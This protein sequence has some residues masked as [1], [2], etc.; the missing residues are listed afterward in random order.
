MEAGPGEKSEKVTLKQENEA[1]EQPER[2]R[3]KPNMN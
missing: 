2:S 1:L 3:T